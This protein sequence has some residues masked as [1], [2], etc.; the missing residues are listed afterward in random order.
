MGG[1][2]VKKAYII[3]R[4][5]GQFQGIVSQ[6]RAMLFLG[7][8]H[9]GSAFAELLN[10]ILNTIPTF[11]RKTYVS[12][13]AKTAPALQDI[14]EQFRSA[15]DGLLLASLY[16]TQKTSL[17]PFTKK[18]I[19]QKDSADLGYPAEISSPLDAD[20]HG[21]AKF[22]SVEDPNYQQVRDV[23]RLFFRSLEPH[24]PAI[25]ASD[26]TKLEELLG[27][28][29]DP[30]LD[31]EVLL[32]RMMRDSCRWILRRDTFRK[33]R[34]G[35]HDGCALLWLRG[36]PGVGK[37][38]LSSSI[39]TSLQ[40]DLSKEAACC[41]YFFNSQDEEKRSIK[42]MLA[43]VA[44][45]IALVSR[46]FRQRLL[47]LHNTVGFSID[48]P[49]A[50]NVWESIFQRLLLQSQ[51]EE[52]PILLVIDGLDEADHPELLIRF[53]SKL[54]SGHNIRILIT[55]RPIKEATAVCHLRIKATLDDITLDDTRDDIRAYA[56]EVLGAILPDAR[57]R[58][59]ICAQIL[60]KSQGSF[61]WVALAIEQLR[62]HWLTPDALRQAL[63]ELPEGMEAFY[64][65]MI[66]T[67]ANQPTRPLAM[68]SRILTWA[69]CAS[70]SLELAELETAIS[71]EFG[72]FLSLRESVAQLCAHF[73]I[74]KKS[75]VTL[76]HDTA[77]AFLLDRDGG[78]LLSIGPHIGHQCIAETCLKFLMDQ[79]KNWRRLLTSSGR[80][81]FDQHPFLSYAVTWWAYHVSQAPSSSGLAAFVQTFL[82]KFALVW[83]HAVAFLGDLRTLTRTGELLR[84]VASQEYSAGSESLGRKHAGELREWS[85]DLI[86]LPGR[87]GNILRLNPLDIYEKIVPFCPTGSIIRR[88]FVAYG[89]LSVLGISESSWERC[90]GR[91]T[92]G[93]EDIVVHVACQGPYFVAATERGVLV[94]AY[95]DSCEEA[96]RIDTNVLLTNSIRSVATSETSSLMAI[97]GG[98]IIQVW[99]LD[100]G[101][102]VISLPVLPENQVLVLSFANQDE[103]L[104]IGYAD[105]SVHC[106]KLESAEEV[107]NQPV[108][109][110]EP[111]PRHPR[112]MS[113][114]PDGLWAVLYCEDD[115]SFCAWRLD[116]PENRP[117]VCL[118]SGYEGRQ[119]YRPRRVMWRSR[120]PSSAFVQYS[121]EDFFE[122]NLEQDTLQQ[123]PHISGQGM[124][125]SPD[126]TRIS[127]YDPESRSVKV[128]SLPEYRA[129][130]EL[131][132]VPWTPVGAISPEGDRL[133]SS[134]GSGHSCDAW[135]LDAMMEADDSG[136]DDHPLH[137]AEPSLK[138]SEHVK[139]VSEL[140]LPNAA[141][142]FVVFDPSGSWFISGDDHGDVFVHDINNPQSVIRCPVRM[143]TSLSFAS[144]LLA[145]SP[146]GRYFALVD[147]E[148][149]VA[150]CS[151]SESA[152]PEEPKL[153]ITLECSI[154]LEKMEPLQLL[155]HPSDELIFISYVTG[156]V[157]VRNSSA[158]TGGVWSS[159]TGSKVCT[160]R[161]VC[162][163]GQ[164]V[165]HPTDSAI[166]LF[167]DRSDCAI[168]AYRWD[169]L[170]EVDLST[171]DA[172]E[173]P[174]HTY[175]SE[176]CVGRINRAVT[177]GD[178]HVVFEGTWVVD[179]PVNFVVWRKTMV[180][181]LE[182]PTERTQPVKDMA[183]LASRFIGCYKGKVVFLDHDYC[184]C[185]WH[186]QDGASS[187]KRHF[188]L[189]K[190]W[191]DLYMLDLCC[192]N[193]QGTVL[194]P[195]NGEVGVIQ[196]G[197]K[198]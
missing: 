15:C 141:I 120:M 2:V 44:F 58:D 21:V 164:W 103:C 46:S 76:V 17:G 153:R 26:R 16:E 112:Y 39:I 134:S 60:E 195:R 91:L 192:V 194:C 149:C 51:G 14:N 47:D 178:R 137:N 124:A 86:R 161:P 19:V 168:R 65:R 90:V 20:H 89:S 170:V 126:D 49:Q 88:Q 105:L 24:A 75:Q 62:Y 144:P 119:T 125:L 61:L 31:L 13:L 96:R 37:S 32:D 185:T 54:E 150:V 82:N 1:L 59:G 93:D 171:G 187:L 116:S 42:R 10:N 188:Y 193:E 29:N 27:S 197:F 113:I 159:K 70:R 176:F 107:W 33:W 23:L 57:L 179:T 98:S 9:R 68:A 22:K 181:D 196:N 155:F 180:V 99:N 108:T 140:R 83:I 106:V 189:P 25:S 53:F 147:P 174:E 142:S 145:W 7:T 157:W 4:F 167:V 160:S 172:I 130:H 184:L 143:S 156:D 71:P 101:E 72:A 165:Q 43:N 50:V 127:A 100:T 97:A 95:T 191:L 6:V 85:R 81:T 74:V 121:D 175:T 139:T 114:S 136:V 177:V 152:I 146:G 87:F 79:K 84:G 138:D 34:D 30:S 182:H 45:Q 80:A 73:V 163:R 8:P 173:G 135:E 18:M 162:C 154:D 11:S 67:I 64:D 48:K 104:L 117:R 52:K 36:L 102:Q 190:D 158:A 115:N 128:W 148:G 5:D 132:L 166:L 28:F 55:S 198:L 40:Q 69:M 38:V 12:E 78:Q 94:V 111:P 35:L 123:I 56:S 77:R 92:V 186:L 109:P 41:Y 63:D 118:P 66:R 133:Y 169:S 183:Q 110:P 129:I 151:V 3:G 122:W 131:R